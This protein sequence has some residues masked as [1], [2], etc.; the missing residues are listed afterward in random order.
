MNPYHFKSGREIAANTMYT[1]EHQQ[2]LP[3]HS[4]GRVGVMVTFKTGKE[5]LAA[6]AVCAHQFTWPRRL[7]DHMTPP[8]RSQ[9]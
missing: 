9:D 5:L 6:K 8:P 2:L 4:T 7:K 3:R 1:T